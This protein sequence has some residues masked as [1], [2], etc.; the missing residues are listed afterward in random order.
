MKKAKKGMSMKKMMEEGNNKP[1]MVCCLDVDKVEITD[2]K[3]KQN[4]RII[5]KFREYVVIIN[6]RKT[7]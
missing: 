4:K 6:V 7:L 1:R 3:I 2:Y 5:Y